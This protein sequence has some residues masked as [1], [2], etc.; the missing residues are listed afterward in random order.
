MAHLFAKNHIQHIKVLSHPLFFF[1][2]H[3]KAFQITII[4]SLIINL[5]WLLHASSP[6][7]FLLQCIRVYLPKKL[8]CC[9]LNLFFACDLA[10]KSI[11]RVATYSS[12]IHVTVTQE[13]IFPT[14]MPSPIVFVIW[15]SQLKPRLHVPV[16][17]QY[18]CVFY[19]LCID[20][21]VITKP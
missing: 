11:G 4:T 5:V 10:S 18:G 1:F 7:A 21:V 15:D 2:N 20:V 16:I 8:R 19:G 12:R 3:I 6:S 9:T 13:P 14:Q 17:V